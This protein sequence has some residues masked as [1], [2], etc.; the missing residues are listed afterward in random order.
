MKTIIGYIRQ[1]LAMKLSLGIVLMAVLI[2]VLVLGILFYQ[3]RSHVGHEAISRASR[4]LDATMM[5]VVRHLN[6]IEDATNTNAWIAIENFQPQALLELSRRIV[7]LNGHVNGCSITAAPNAIPECGRYFSAYSVRLG[8]SIVTEREK[9][10]EYFDKVWYKTPVK[11]GRACWVDP[12]DDYNEGTLSAEDIIASYSRPLY[13]GAGRLLGVIS[14]DL[15]LPKLAQVLEAEIPFANA[16]FFMLGRDGRYLVHSDSTKLNTPTI[17]DTATA[18]D[19][20]DIVALGHEMTTGKSGTMEVVVGDKPCL[21]SYR[22]LPGT[23]WSLALVCPR[24]DIFKSYYKLTYITLPF[25]VIGLIFILLLCQRVVAQ[26]VMPLRRLLQQCQSIA[27]GNYEEHIP[28]SKRNDVV[29]RLQNSFAAMQHSIE[30]HV[31]DINKVND[32]TRLRNVELQQAR[33]MAEN[34]MRQKTLFIQN[35]THQIR[36]PLNIVMGFSQILRDNLGQLPKE[37]LAEIAGMMGHNARHLSRMVLMLYDSSDTARSD[38]TRCQRNEQVNCNDVARQSIDFTCQHFPEM[39]VNFS[40]TLPDDFTIHSNSLY[41]MRSLRELL[42]N[43]AKYSDAQHVVLAITST[44]TTVRFTV[45][46][47]GPGIDADHLERMFE[48]FAKAD[49][50]SEG[51]GLG[52]PLTKQHAMNLGGDLTLDPSYHQGCRF[53]LELPI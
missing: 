16:Y 28:Q 41:L 39:V 29:G 34:S 25:V 45:E 2:F 24:S 36:T 43:A 4:T 51:L 52:L 32:E 19:H 42:Y 40:T 17:F 7:V 49:D 31:A 8:D 44:D 18:K 53:T 35:M 13:D 48:P 47:Q 11:R 33:Q 5:H 37:E 23:Q 27:Q 26:S 30:H 1:S 9:P 20:P 3:A 22:P 38:E 15:A 14:T 21:V 10:Y 6:T 50:L 12:F 46:D